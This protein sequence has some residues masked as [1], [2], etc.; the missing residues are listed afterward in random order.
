MKY[1]GKVAMWLNFPVILPIV[2]IAYCIFTQNK[3]LLLS[4]IIG[5]SIVVFW[6]IWTLPNYIILDKDTI[7]IRFGFHKKKIILTDISTLRKTNDPTQSYAL[8]LDRIKI[9]Y[10]S[11]TSSSDEIMISVKQNDILIE[12]IIKK[13]PHI[14]YIQ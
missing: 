13:N 6:I 3:N 7:L 1:K 9:G 8:S 12:E 11:L 5:I 14:K 4:L 2:F 10:S